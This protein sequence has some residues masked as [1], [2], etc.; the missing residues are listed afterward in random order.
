MNDIAP[1]PTLDSV[2]QPLPTA[3]VESRRYGSA[4]W[5]VPLLALVVVAGFVLREWWTRGPRIMVEIPRATGIEAGRTMVFSRGVPIGTVERVRLDE[6]LEHPVVD[7]QLER[8]AHAFA[9]DGAVYWVVT[10]S[11]NFHGVSGLE[12]LASGPVLEARPGDATAT[13]LAEFKA[14]GRA[15]SDASGIPGL[16]LEL[17]SPRLGSIRVGSP[18]TYRDVEVGEVIDTELAPDSTSG[19]IHIVIGERYAGLVRASTQF[20]GRGGLGLDLGMTGFKLRT[21][22]LESIIGG[23]IAFATPESDAPAA[24]SGATY[25]LLDEEPKGWIKWSPKVTLPP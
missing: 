1:E 13:L 20:W 14:L 17:H 23:G 18:V 11:I 5:F 8:W 12:T 6:A 24:V 4:V 15:P 21:E 3:V 9:R 16:R 7:I 25:E 22:S 19:R 10:P 2:S